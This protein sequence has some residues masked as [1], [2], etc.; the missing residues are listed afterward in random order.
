MQIGQLS[1]QLGLGTSLV[2][3]HKMQLLFPLVFA[4]RLVSS[5]R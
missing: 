5:D 1:V 2:D 4:Y 3:W